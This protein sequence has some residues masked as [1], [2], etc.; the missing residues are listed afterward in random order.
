MSSEALLWRRLSSEL[1]ERIE[2]FAGVAGVCL[3]DLATGE[4]LS[5][6]GD[7]AFP[8]ASTIKIAVL[9]HVLER[10]ERGVL[11]LDERVEV[12]TSVHVPGSGVLAH[13]DGA[14]AMTGRDLAT[15]MIVSSDNTA[16][17]LCIEW[18]TFAGVNEMLERLGFTRTRL[19]RKMLDEA[20]VAAGDE[21]LS[22]PVDMVGFLAMVHRGAALH[23][24]VT[25]RDAG[26]STRVASGA[27]LRYGVAPLEPDG[28]SAGPGLSP[29][30]CAEVLRI[31]RKPKDGYLALG[32]PPGVVVANKAGATS[33]VRNDAGIVLLAKRPYALC[34]MTSY[35]TQGPAAQERFL[36]ELAG[37]VHRY[38]TTLD[39][40]GP[41]GQGV[42]Y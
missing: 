22:S 27:S 16:A 15:L 8:T 32:L 37:T 17:N 26:C 33:L 12:T 18:A 23:E 25:D 30:V 38:M 28:T 9:A 19:A 40:A 11:D 29:A 21:N 3:R 1:E 6:R 31:L 5:A 14:V 13:L 39:L 24:G 41:W 4:E 42:A 34:V 2:E 7:E 36:G 35:G 10:G 20:A